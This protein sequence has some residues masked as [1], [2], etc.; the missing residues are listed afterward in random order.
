MVLS[1]T[2]EGYT[3][4]K[5]KLN[6]WTEVLTVKYEVSFE[7]VNITFNDLTVSF[8][9]GRAFCFLTLIKPLIKFQLLDDECF[10][11]V[12]T[13]FTKHDINN[14][15]I[16]S[17]INIVLK[18]MVSADIN[19]NDI[20]H[21][22]SR[23]L[24]ALSYVGT[25]FNRLRGN[26]V[27]LYTL[28]KLQEAFPEFGD[29]IYTD[30]DEN[31]Q[32]SDIEDNIAE[33]QSKGKTL[34]SK[35]PSS[36]GDMVRSGAMV[37]FKQMSQCVFV[38]GF[39]PNL[40]GETIPWL[41]NTSFLRGLRNCKD[42]FIITKAARKASINNFAYTKKSGYLGRKLIL[43][44][45]NN[46]LDEN[47]KSACSS[48]NRVLVNIDSEKTLAS[49]EGRYYT[50]T[51][52]TTINQAMKSKSVGLITSV[53]KKLIGKK[54][55]LWDPVTCSNDKV[56]S[57]CYG[58]MHAIN[59]SYHAAVVAASLL[60]ASMLQ[61]FLSTKHLLHTDTDKVEL[62]DGFDEYFTVD[63][64][65]LRIKDGYSVIITDT[66]END[67][68]EDLLTSS[69]K[70]VKHLKRK[71][72]ELPYE[73]IRD[74]ELNEPAEI[75]IGKLNAPKLEDGTPV[76]KLIL[77]NNE[78]KK[79]MLQ[80]LD[81]IQKKAHLGV[82][83]Y[84]DAIAKFMVLLNKSNIYLT[85]V[86]VSMILRRLFRDVND[87]YKL[88]DWRKAGADYQ[89]ITLPQAIEFDKLGT[90]LIFEKHKKQLRNVDIL[91]RNGESLM[92]PLYT[93]RT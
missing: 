84:N 79:S 71:K 75:L 26:T 43:S 82:E 63:K 8:K 77:Q 3:S 48:T 6:D 42:F 1:N 23:S 50:N 89:F 29:L 66:T 22:V 20:N 53:S 17:S 76:F 57:V 68:S 7:D 64:D 78:I 91:E 40:S 74:V 18:R 83:T 58:K 30:L 90:S 46:F 88:P 92:D 41:V 32:I 25:Y 15:A 14:S 59:G 19:V 56:C 72:G 37:N 39:K 13:Q 28:F 21:S 33:I 51:N 60:G 27:S 34:L 24:H 87:K 5:N 16:D 93:P 2:K 31:R 10:K 69:F 67:F 55:Y 73:I 12:Y 49:L 38:I 65:Q 86:H 4:L 54:V 35:A 36:L 52:G 11:A 80:L 44:V 85:H 81:L 47:P 9:K 45:L 62:F 61:N 70:I